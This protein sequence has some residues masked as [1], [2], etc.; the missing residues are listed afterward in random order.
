MPNTAR[1][2]AMMPRTATESSN[3][4]TKILILLPTEKSKLL[5]QWKGPFTVI[6]QKNKVDEVVDFGTKNRLFPINLLKR[7]EDRDAVFHGLTA[8]TCS[9]KA[10]EFKQPETEDIPTVPLTK[11]QDYTDVEISREV[12]RAQAEALNELVSSYTDIFSNQPGRTE[13]EVCHLQMKTHVPV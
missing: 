3:L 10:G 2:F 13:L 6:E 8:A 1:R 4:A 5:L 11:T 12:T 7:Y 9:A